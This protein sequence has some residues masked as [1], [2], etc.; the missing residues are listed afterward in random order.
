P[1]AQHDVGNVRHRVAE[2]GA[3]PALYM[4]QFRCASGEKGQDT[5]DTL[6]GAEEVSDGVHALRELERPYTR[7]VEQERALVRV[8]WGRVHPWSHIQKYSLPF[9]PPLHYGRG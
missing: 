7:L 2:Q 3:E 5:S 6:G 4:P 1:A 8:G 9:P